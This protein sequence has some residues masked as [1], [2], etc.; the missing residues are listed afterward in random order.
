TRLLTNKWTHFLVLLALLGGAVYFS[1]SNHELRKRLQYA[2]FD[3]YNKLKPRPPSDRVAIVDLDEASLTELGQW[4]FPRTVMADWVKSLNDLGA[5][6]IAF[7]IVFAEADRTSPARMAG[8]LPAGDAYDPVK[9][10]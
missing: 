9:A 2:T 10:A 8:T 5:N 6:V 4:P 7:D 1:G 3:T